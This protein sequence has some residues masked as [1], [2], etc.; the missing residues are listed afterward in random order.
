MSSQFFGN[1]S[2]ESEMCNVMAVLNTENIYF[3]ISSQILAFLQSFT[4]AK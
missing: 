2:V 1:V 4:V 3:G